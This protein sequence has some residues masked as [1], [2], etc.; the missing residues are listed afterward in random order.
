[1]KF[2]PDIIYLSK[3]E[4][5]TAI[6]K[7]KIPFIVTF[8][9]EEDVNNFRKFM[10]YMSNGPKLMTSVSKHQIQNLQEKYKKKATIILNGV[11]SKI[12]KPLK[13]TKQKRNVVL[14]VGRFIDWKGVLE[15]I[16]VAKQLPEYEFWFA[17]QG[18]L[19]KI[20]KGKN[21]KNLG[22]K[23][24][25]ELVKLYNQAT[26]CTFPSWHEPFG[27][28]GLEAMSCGKPVIATPLGFS[29]Y[30]EDEKEG[31]IIPAKNEK[32]LKNAIVSLMKNPKKRKMIEKNARKKALK[33]SWD[34]VA[35]QYL[36]VFR[37]VI[38][39]N[40]KTKHKK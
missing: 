37:E 17:G 2:K 19:N 33:Y 13:N 26:I 23:S 34:K 31:I 15:I 22:F 25:K 21:I 7:C 24:T 4:L 30:I 36:K 8:H 9:S 12:F 14:F 10:C 40:E 39:E 32:T 3:V 29:E 28:V 5:F 27:L 11:D 16:N 35:K 20:I 38:K 18:P 6:Y 1:M